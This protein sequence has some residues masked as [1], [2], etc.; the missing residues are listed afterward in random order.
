MNRRHKKKHHRHHRHHRSEHESDVNEPAQIRASEDEGLSNIYDCPKVPA[1]PVASSEL[2]TIDNEALQQL[3]QSEEVVYDVPRSNPPRKVEKEAIYVN[4]QNQFEN[5]SQDYD[6]PR[7]VTLSTQQQQQVI[8]LV[9]LSEVTDGSF[10]F[11]S[12]SVLP[13]LFH[14]IDFSRYSNV[15]SSVMPKHNSIVSG[16][17]IGTYIS[18]T[19]T[20]NLFFFRLK[21]KDQTSNTTFQP[22]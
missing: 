7:T 20:M 6:V 9:Q 16:Q 21:N 4:N 3:Q 19:S 22:K 13:L 2:T 10:D 11:L 12:L 15:A 5:S 17:Q 18:M 14:K 8:L 1:I